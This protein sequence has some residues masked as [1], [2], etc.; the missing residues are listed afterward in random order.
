[1][2]TLRR[3]MV[4]R[5]DPVAVAVGADVVEASEVIVRVS[6]S[7][8][9]GG[10]SEHVVTGRRRLSYDLNLDCGAWRDVAG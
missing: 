7:D 6:I 4:V 2:A 9:S 1:M 5:E 8:A 10:C 3:V